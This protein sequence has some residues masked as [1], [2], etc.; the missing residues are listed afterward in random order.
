MAIDLA[1][2][3]STDSRL[4]SLGPVGPEGVQYEKIFPKSDQWLNYRRK[5]YAT[6][7][8]RLENFAVYLN[9]FQA[10]HNNNNNKELSA[11]IKNHSLEALK[12]YF[13]NNSLCPQ[14]ERFYV[15]ILFFDWKIKISAINDG[16]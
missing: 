10:N 15:Q 6:N 2:G 13:N 5:G 12:R 8:F 3:H 9:G 4:V 7:A 1:P 14:T 16:K 11:H